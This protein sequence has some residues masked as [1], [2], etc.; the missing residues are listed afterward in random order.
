MSEESV[1]HNMT[2]LVLAALVGLAIGVLATGGAAPVQLDAQQWEAVND[3]CRQAA[4]DSLLNATDLS[5][6]A[7]QEFYLK[8]AEAYTQLA[9]FGVSCAQDP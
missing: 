5:L 2:R 7:D 9:G 3:S 8:A 4:T 1:S 6:K